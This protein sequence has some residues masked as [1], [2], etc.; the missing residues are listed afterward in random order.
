MAAR[1]PRDF[2]LSPERYREQLQ[3]AT[4]ATRDLFYHEAP[5]RWEI[6]VKAS[7]TRQQTFA[8][9]EADLVAQ[10]EETGV[11]VRT[12][13]AGRHGFAAVSDL[14]ST[15]SRRAVD[16]AHRA[17]VDI[18]FD[19]LPPEHLLGE[20]TLAHRAELA[21]PGWAT[22]FCDA[23][24][25]EIHQC[26]SGRVLTQR[27]I[28]QEGVFGWILTTSEEHTSR[29]E[30]VGTSLLC[31]VTLRDH[32][33][34]T[35]REIAYLSKP[36]SCEPKALAAQVVDRVLLSN[37]RTTTASGI[38][39]VLL[40]REV[41]AHVVGELIPVLTATPGDGDSLSSLVDRDGMLMSGGVTVVDD[42][43]I[44][45]GPVAAPCD[46]EGLP[47][48][49]V[50]LV[51]DGVPR[52]Q[53]ASFRDATL[54]HEAPRGGARRVS[55]RD[56]PA[57]GSSNII[58]NSPEQSSPATLLA[59]VDRAAYLLRPIAPV[60]IDVDRDFFRLLAAG[61]WLE[62]G[63]ITGWQPA[64]EISGS[65]GQLLRRIDGV[66]T[67]H[68]WYQTRHGFIASPSLLLR[69]QSVSA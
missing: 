56:Y 9:D 39:D 53:I 52:H 14:E 17:E 25:S 55:Y 27:T 32:C 11:A 63:K 20:T 35:W 19:P 60:T 59:D 21:P 43:A 47:A 28:L 10:T 57:S 58:V 41:V 26:S 42:R 12:Y 45:D 2:E 38:R 4:I 23:L 3:R 66:G 48:R 34:G 67:D 40:H 29:F 15:A 33:A 54:C 68:R 50:L 6:F 51:E 46:G 36:A 18:P 22:H 62:A 5:G 37:S 69:H 13:S 64:I 31:E 8:Q 24:R 61:V 7:C 49:R 1:T 16:D 44:K 30:T 65:I